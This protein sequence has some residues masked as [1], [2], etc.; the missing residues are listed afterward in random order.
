MGAKRHLQVVPLVL[1]AGALIAIEKHNRKIRALLE[2][3]RFAHASMYVPA[4]V[5]AQVIRSKERQVMIRKALYSRYT[6]LVP[7]DG[8]VAEMVGILCGRTQTTDIVDASVVV[9][10]QLYGATI[11]TSDPEDISR[12]HPSVALEVV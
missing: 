1:D 8:P 3:A 2:V 7:L 11:I 5:V 4:P 9:V 10:A 12:L 6:T